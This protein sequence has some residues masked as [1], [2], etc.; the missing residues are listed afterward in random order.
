MAMAIPVNANISKF[1]EFWPPTLR[2]NMV[3][4]EFSKESPTQFLWPFNVETREHV[5]P[6]KSTLNVWNQ[7]SCTQKNSLFVK[8]ST[9]VTYA[10]CVCHLLFGRGK[11]PT[12]PS[13]IWVSLLFTCIRPT[14]CGWFNEEPT[15][16]GSIPT[17][18]NEWCWI[19]FQNR[20]CTHTHTYTHTD[21]MHQNMYYPC[22]AW[23]FGLV[24]RGPDLQTIEV[25]WGSRYK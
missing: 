24:L 25:I 17:R 5:K 2:E 10:P 20:V 1:G 6:V 18:S 4:S 3:Q 14:S 15:M 7:T 12:C 11:C 8:P 9:L 23:K 19:A 21:D 16:H 13:C 22:F